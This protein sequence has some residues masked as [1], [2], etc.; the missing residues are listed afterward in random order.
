MTVPV[1]NPIVDYVGNGITTVFAFPFRVLSAGD[2]TVTINGLVPMIPYTVSGI[3]DDAGAVTFSTAPALGAKIQLFRS[4]ALKRDEDYQDN[5]DLLADTVNGD[6]DRIWMALQGQGYLIGSG[7][8]S[9]SRALMLGRDD[10]SGS[11]AYRANNNRI[12]NL[13]YPVSDTD[14]ATYGSARD[15]AEQ[16]T[17][18]A[19]GALGAFLQNGA[20]AVV[21]TFQS[22]M[23]DGFIT[24]KDFNA[25]GGGVD[26]SHPFDLAAAAAGLNGQVSVPAGSWRVETTPSTP[27]TWLVDAQAT[28]SGAGTL[29]GRIV[30]LGNGGSASK[31]TKIGA[32]TAWL[33]ALRPFTESIAELSVLSTIGQIGIIGASRTSDFGMAG[34]Q[35]CIG[36]SGYA[37]NNNT[38]AL[39][40]AYGGYFEARRQVGAG[41]T[42][43][44]E[45]DI[46]NFGSVGVVYPGNV[47]APD[48]TSC[49]WL[50]SGGDI[51]GAQGASLAL[52]IIANGAPF[53]KG[54]VI[55]TGAVTAYSGEAVAFGLGRQ[56]GIVW[57]D[58]GTNKV[59]RIRSDATAASIG[60]VF[61]NNTLN[62][63]DMS[64]VNAYTMGDNGVL[65]IAKGT[66]GFYFLGTK[67][68]G[69]RITGWG[70]A[71]GA[72]R[73][74]LSASTATL[75]Q[76]AA[77]VAA[78][79]NDLTT[80]GIIGA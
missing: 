44:V 32:P 34:S 16:I 3:G 35:G 42:Q 55:Q 60:L 21:R 59:A 79:I 4:V 74:A 80:H 62:V 70:V 57:Y 52:G 46:V 7:D 41:I 63:Q 39:Q 45:I 73:A 27:V 61:S 64:G 48:L 67:V 50:A 58:S 10:V 18:G 28:L 71:T 11:G 22:K 51:A 76:V 43:A 37:N 36:V 19:Q 12:Q 53:D 29:S 49:L 38:S 6:F 33:E 25:L 78:L 30:K 2:L 9:I 77:A 26:D 14:A 8:P 54:I 1:Q 24:P 17:T 20:G 23:R 13:G 75:P 68:L 15:I 31:G 56:N 47:Y 40:T 65:N 72:N 69:W 66:G 5:G